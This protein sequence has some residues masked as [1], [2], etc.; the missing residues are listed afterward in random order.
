METKGELSEALED[1]LE[2]I[3][4]IIIKNSAVRVKDIAAELKVKNPS[5]TSALQALTKRGLI[6]YEPYGVITLTKTGL[7]LALK[8]TEKHR[9]LKNFLAH[10][11]GIQPAVA[12]DTACRMEHVIPR[13]V[14]VKLVQFIKFLYISQGADGDWIE[15]FRKFSSKDSTKK[16]DSGKLEQYFQGTGFT[17]EGGSD[18]AGKA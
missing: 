9:L 4:R 18:V 2:V 7:D 16:L 14:Y 8:T 17:F 15:D 10:V 11:L 6:N 13:D 5:V 12:N 1:Y 3:Y